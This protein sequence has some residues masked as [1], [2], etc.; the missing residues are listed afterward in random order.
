MLLQDLLTR[1]FIYAKCAFGG[2]LDDATIHNRHQCGHGIHLV[3]EYCSLTAKDFE[4]YVSI[5]ATMERETARP[6]SL[7]L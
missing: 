6:F 1:L 2:N 3:S 4:D 7:I 5:L